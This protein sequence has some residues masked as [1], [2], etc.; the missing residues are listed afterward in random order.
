M[1]ALIM[2]GGAGS[3]LNMGEKP[4]VTICGRPMISY[5]I[6]AF[7][8][9]EFD[10]VVVLTPQT[11]FTRNWCH[12]QGIDFLTA[13]GSGYVEDIIETVLELEESEPLFTSV[14]D[15]PCLQAPILH[16]I[17]SEYQKS[18]KEA[19]STWVP[20][21][22]R[23]HQGEMGGYEETVD[24][25]RARAAGVNILTGA[26]IGKSQDEL[27]LLIPDSNLAYN[28]NTREDLSAV[29]RILCGRE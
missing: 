1:L 14:A 28:I 19:C 21:Y 11:P 9:A 4:M 15:I 22:L 13:T 23:G 26:H 17:L 5:V 2:A 25:V 18:R 29:Q 8:L 12:V 27:R 16:T 24:G 6:D 3:R 20:W 7:L 10:V